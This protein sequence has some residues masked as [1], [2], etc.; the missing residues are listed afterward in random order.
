MECIAQMGVAVC[1]ENRVEGAS[2]INRVWLISQ[3]TVK[4]DDARKKKKKNISKN[5]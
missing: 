3:N 5:L 2:N 1:K 4:S